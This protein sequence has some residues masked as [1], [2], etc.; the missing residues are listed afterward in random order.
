MSKVIIARL[1]PEGAP[2]FCCP[3]VLISDHPRFITGTRFDYGFLSI[4]LEEG[5]S[6]V[7]VGN[8]IEKFAKRWKD[9]DLVRLEAPEE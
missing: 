9:G 8:R 2:Y 3:V 6:V 4:S 1:E 7:F 5:Y